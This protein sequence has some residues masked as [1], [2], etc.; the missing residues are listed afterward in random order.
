MYPSITKSITMNQ[1]NM[2]TIRYQDELQRQFNGLPNTLQDIIGHYNVLHRTLMLSVLDE[3]M[4]IREQDFIPLCEN[5]DCD[6]PLYDTND[7]EY[8]S[9]YIINGVSHFCC[10]YCASK[11]EAEMRIYHRAALRKKAKMNAMVKH[12]H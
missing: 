5:L 6:Q 11:G 1:Q 12:L 10:E 7:S 9:R 3:Y 8:V 2:N 4:C